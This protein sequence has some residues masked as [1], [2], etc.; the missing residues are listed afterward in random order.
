MNRNQLSQD[1]EFVL[2]KKRHLPQG[3]LQKWGW[4]PLSIVFV[5]V[6]GIA[7][8]LLFGCGTSDTSVGPEP[9]GSMWECEKAPHIW[10]ALNSYDSDGYGYFDL[11]VNAEVIRCRAELDVLLTTMT[12]GHWKQTEI[13]DPQLGPP[14]PTWTGSGISDKLD[15]GVRINGSDAIP[16]ATLTPLPDDKAITIEK[17]SKQ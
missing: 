11:V 5:V 10:I 2:R 14:P 12:D 9:V 6:L 15:M 16:M 17:E 8:L 4:L 13:G 1:A 7:G 3:D